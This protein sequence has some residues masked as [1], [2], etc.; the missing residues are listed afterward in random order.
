MSASISTLGI[1][2]HQDS[3]V[4][5]T[6]T[7]AARIESIDLLRGT[8]MII[9]ALDHAR[10]FF[11][12]TAFL[13]DPV[14]LQHTSAALYFTRWITHF[15]APVFIFLAGVSAYLYGARRS[16]R[17]LSRFLFTRGLWLVFAELFIFTLAWT[18]NIEYAF[19]SLQVIWVIGICM[20]LLS[21]VVYMSRGAIL[22]AGLLVVAGHNL[23]DGVHVPGHGLS[24]FVWS[25][26]HEPGY[27]SFGSVSFK[28][29]YPVL[30]W[31]GVMAIGYSCGPVFSAG[32]GVYRRK[33]VLLQLAAGMIGLFFLL[34][35]FN[36][37]GQAAEWAPQADATFSVLS[38][39]NV[40]KYPPSLLYLLITLGPAFAFLSVAER[41][42]N[43]WAAG[44]SVYGRVPM[45][46]YFLHLLLIHVLAVIAA[47]ATGFPATSM[48][49]KSMHMNET[50]VLNGYGFDLPVVFL[51]WAAVV[52]ALYPACK[53]YDA[54]KTKHGTGKWWLSY[55]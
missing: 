21:A 50:H 52:L 15:C 29:L 22:L 39:M 13:Y 30:P 1:A 45:F 35:F 5:V 48:V 14:D 55:L 24:A 8:V 6:G 25:L 9:M 36:L 2:L 11:H 10:H 20:M 31:I 43:R 28:V 19:F 33:R 46:Y 37:Y 16:T 27:F 38:F 34:R 17:E 54:Y 3:S 40:T 4:P 44:V 47:V 42:L 23:L 41:P 32:Y 51:V 18:F 7:K 26:L 53:W 12:E 49:I